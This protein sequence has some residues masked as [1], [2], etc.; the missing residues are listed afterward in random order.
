M[1]NMWSPGPEALQRVTPSDLHLRILIVEDDAVVAADIE[2]IVN[3]LGHAVAGMA[4]SGE[5]TI[6]L[7]DQSSPDLVLI[8]I[9]LAGPMDGIELAGRIRSQLDTPVVFISGYSADEVIRRAVSTGSHAYLTKPFRPADLNAAIRIAVNGSASRRCKPNG[10]SPDRDSR[11]G[12]LTERER[13]VLGLIGEGRRTKEIASE[14]G[15]TFKT[16]V[17]HRSNIMDKLGIHEGPNLVR[18]AIRTGFSRP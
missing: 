2:Q 6:R 16:A 14:L 11:V 17:T 7:L 15:I 10:I 18:F 8:D 9:G 3:D 1:M 4:D 13:T 5:E 12:L